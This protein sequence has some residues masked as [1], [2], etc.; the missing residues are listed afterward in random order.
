MQD[1]HVVWDLPDE[2]EGNIAHIAE[3][4]FT[5]EDVE[6][7]LFGPNSETTVST[8]S[9]LPITFGFTSTGHYIAVVW[10]HIQDDP[11]T[12]RP[13]TAYRVPEPRARRW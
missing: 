11:L 10:E 13:I 1:A 9:G 7:V 3:H 5:Q 2:P 12:M 8:S 6:D 4:G